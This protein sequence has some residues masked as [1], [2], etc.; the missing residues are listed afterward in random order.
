[1]KKFFRLIL[2]IFSII[3]IYIFYKSELVF[4]GTI[5]EHYFVPFIT[6]IAL[7]IF[8]V[9]VSN[10]SKLIQK[11]FL[12]AI[13]SIFFTLY[14][15]ESY[16]IFKIFPF[17]NNNNFNFDKRSI[18]QLYKDIKKNENVF[19]T[20]GSYTNQLHLEIFSDIFPL[21]GFSNINTI[22]CNELGYYSEYLS[23]RYGFNNPDKEWDS[24]EIEYLLVGDS[25]VHGACVNRP[26]DIASVL[27]ELSKK[28]VLNL[29][30]GATGP[31][32]QYAILREY[33]TPKVKKIFWVYFE[34]N[35]LDDLS[36]ELNSRPLKKY[37]TDLN[38]SQNLKL[39]QNQIDDLY[40]KYYVPRFLEQ[41]QE[42][43]ISKNFFITFIKLTYTRNLFLSSASSNVLPSFKNILILTKDLAYKNNTKLYFVYLPSFYNY[44]SINYNTKKKDDI[45]L[46][47]NNLDIPF[48]DIDN[49][50]FKN[51]QYP[52]KLFPFEKFGHYTIEGYRKV[53]SKI[54]EKTK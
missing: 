5:R 40:T 21:S 53:S 8:T 7:I 45:K 27:R 51:E 22:Y 16:L 33:L 9:V 44:A 19:L 52:L 31:L 1:M 50:V 39:K 47:V 49:E 12:I 15:F 24:E 46:I 10:L 29:G 28:N 41:N 42:N 37:L 11:Y 34:L 6:L 13:L 43:I 48:I 4:M 30:Q 14:L 25:F 36:K 3:L 38:F 18:F 26:Y 35:D 23:D 17:S 2:S 20:V 54:Y 32:T